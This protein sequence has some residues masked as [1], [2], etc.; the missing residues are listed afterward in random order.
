MNSSVQRLCDQGSVSLEPLPVGQVVEMFL[1][2][3]KHVSLSNI[4]SRLDTGH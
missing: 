1:R 3:K 2:P 4:H